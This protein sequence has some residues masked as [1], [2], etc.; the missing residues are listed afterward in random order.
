MR[1]YQLLTQ[2]QI[3]QLLQLQSPLNF[4]QKWSKPNNGINVRRPYHNFNQ[5][6]QFYIEMFSLTKYFSMNYFSSTTIN[7]WRAIL[8]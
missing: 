1:F 2:L 3:L 6:S 7:E 4:I 8:I 5:I